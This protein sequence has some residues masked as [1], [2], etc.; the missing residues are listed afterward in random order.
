MARRC[1]R[2]TSR[3]TEAQPTPARSAAA[4]AILLLCVGLLPPAAQAGLYTASDQITLLTQDNVESVLVNSTAAAVVEFYASWCGHC[5]SFSPIYKS[6]ARDITGWYEPGWS[7]VAP[8]LL[9]K[10]ELTVLIQLPS[11]ASRETLHPARKR[12]LVQER[13][14]LFISIFFILTKHIT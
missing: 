13:V 7:H 9:R 3:L 4:A 5:V 11:R 8:G 1:S 2:A 14:R 12:K 6:L 10:Q